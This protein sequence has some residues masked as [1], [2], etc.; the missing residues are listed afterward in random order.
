MNFKKFNSIGDSEPRAWSQS[1][2]TKFGKEEDD[3]DELPV[4]Y[5]DEFD[6]DSESEEEEEEEEE[7]TV[8]ETETETD[9]EST[10]SKKS[11]NPIKRAR[12]PV[13]NTVFVILKEELDFMVE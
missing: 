3:E 4:P 6:E 11:K 9:T 13:Q 12:C 10:G 1:I 7:E 8:T 5:C 2:G